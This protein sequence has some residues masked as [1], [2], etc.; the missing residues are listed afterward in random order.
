MP[1][2][3]AHALPL[4]HDSG[5]HPVRPLSPEVTTLCTAYAGK[6]VRR[7]EKCRSSNSNFEEQIRC[8]Q[9]LGHSPPD[10]PNSKPRQVRVHQPRVHQRRA[11]LV[12]SL[13]S[14]LQV[15]PGKPR[16]PQRAAAVRV[17]QGLAPLSALLPRT[18]PHAPAQPRPLVGAL[19]Q[20]PEGPLLYRARALGCKAVPEPDA[21]GKVG[22]V[23]MLCSTGM[24]SFVH[25]R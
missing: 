13:F 4:G 3:W 20:Q 11:L 12:P 21:R 5:G 10:I 6:I 22:L 2:V 9:T 14:T 7:K 23:H 16:V 15:L 17:P 24:L 19:C 1:C 8:F 25:T 18:G